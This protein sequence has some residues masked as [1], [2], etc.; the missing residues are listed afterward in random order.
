MACK[1]KCQDASL[2]EVLGAYFPRNNTAV[3]AFKRNA[4]L[5]ELKV[6]AFFGIA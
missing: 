3:E 6:K 4:R 5:C 1:E 2:L